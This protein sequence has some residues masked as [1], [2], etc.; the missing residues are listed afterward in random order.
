MIQV[1]RA[2]KF[3]PQAD[4][5]W[6]Y[7]DPPVLIPALSVLYKKHA[8]ILSK[9]VAEA[10]RWNL[11]YTLAHHTGTV[12]AVTPQRTRA[13]F[14]YQT[15]LPFDIDLADT[16][17][18]LD[19]AAVV[20]KVIEAPLEALVVLVSG[21]GI[22]ILA[23]LRTPIRSVDYFDENK[24]AYRAICV[25]VNDGLA[26][27]KLPGH[28]DPV[29]FEPARIFRMPGSRNDK[30]DK[31]STEC[32]LV[33]NSEATL[34]F[35]LYKLSGLKAMHAENI[36]PVDIRRKYPTPDFRQMVKE[37]GF[38]QWTLEK[39]S[40]VHEPH[41]FDLIS[42]LA[43]APADALADTHFGEATPKQL[44]AYVADN[45]TASVSLKRDGFDAKWDHGKTYGA[46][47]CST[48]QNH[49]IGGCEKCPHYG[50]IPTPLAL[51]SDD[52]IGSE[53][54]GFWVLNSKG[55]PSHPH[56][57]DL[58]K[59]YRGGFPYVVASGERVMSFEETHYVETS[60]LV[61]KSWLERKVAPSEPLRELHRNEFLHKIKT[62]G[63]ISESME[64]HLFNES[65]RGKLNCKNGVL[66]I[67]AGKL[68]H[69]LSSIGF[70]YVLPYDYVADLTSE[71][72]IDWLA[73]V[74]GQRVDLMESIL[75]LM[76]YMLWPRYDDH[77]FAY[78]VGEGSNGKSTLLHIMQEIVGVD[79]YTTISLQQLGVNKYAPSMLEGKLVNLAEEASGGE[80]TYEAMNQVKT[81]SAGG[82]IQGE[83][84][85]KDLFTFVNQAKLYFSANKP[86]KFQESGLAIKRRM[87]VIPF[88]HEIS[89]PDSR[90]EYK[91]IAEIPAIVSMLIRRIQENVT[92]NGGRFMVHRGGE[93][94]ARAQAQVLTAGNTVVEWANAC[95]ESS[96][97]VP[98]SEALS[99]AVAYEHYRKWAEAAG[100]RNL[101]TKNSFGR[102]MCQ[103]VITRS[104]GEMSELIRVGGGMMRVYRRTRFKEVME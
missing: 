101:K 26:A 32:R 73:T 94:A 40:E 103:L 31:P 49:W 92:R 59:V 15:V 4:V 99:V 64:T 33:Q 13:T 37:C 44:A 8:E 3:H 29:V 83:K 78:F 22:H 85:F 84:K 51:R 53:A 25:K 17:R 63:S 41:L 89:A 69:H 56:Y 45:A 24:P 46:R 98:E 39:P 66:D 23:G 7:T 82:T 9:H 21:N 52:H 43:P 36:P 61:I 16:A 28:A 20:A 97:D 77:L 60:P 93:A 18:P 12:D 2:R 19:Y 48:I 54:N 104:N 75:D 55:Q 50:K 62:V 67:V 30:K 74:T 38:I 79:N 6:V 11:F 96:T 14:E 10:E 88:D 71:L 65:T 86:P 80:M 58:T 81:L 91:L 42:L 1:I 70:K 5:A 87:L 102:D 47:K 35:D 72:F 68:T 95:I 57:E 27:A 100:H 34:E 90:I 76:A